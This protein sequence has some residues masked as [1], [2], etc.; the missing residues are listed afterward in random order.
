MVRIRRTFIVLT[1]F[2]ATLILAVSTGA[3][4]YADATEADFELSDF[5][6]VGGEHYCNGTD[7]NEA[8]FRVKINEAA[9]EKIIKVRYDVIKMTSKAD[10]VTVDDEN[11]VTLSPGQVKISENNVIEKSEITK[12]PNTSKYAFTVKTNEN[13]AF[14]FSV[15]YYDSENKENVCYG[16][17]YGED[18]S[19]KNNI[20]YCFKIDNSNPSAYYDDVTFDSGYWVFD[21]FIKGNLNSDAASADSGIKSFAVVKRTA[22]GE[23]IIDRVENIG[24]TQYRYKLKI[25]KEKAAYYLDIVDYA[26]N[27]TTSKIVEFNDVSYDAGFETAVTNKLTKLKSDEKY[28]ATFVEKFQ[29]S[30]DEYYFCIQSVDATEAD[31][32]A[33]MAVCYD[34]MS[35]AADYDKMC[36]NGLS[37][38]TVKNYNTEYF[39]GEIELTDSSSFPVKYGDNAVTTIS[40]AMFDAKTVD[41]TAEKQ[42]LGIKDAKTIY[43]VSI[44][45][46]IDG[47]TVISKCE[48][49]AAIKI[50]TELKKGDAYVVMTVD[51]ETKEYIVCDYLVGNGYTVVYLPYSSGVLNIFT[52]VKSDLLWLWS[53]TA[54]P[55]IAAAVVI[56]IIIKKKK[57][58]TNGKKEK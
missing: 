41:K 34:Y 21:V 10:T 28:S 51:G 25:T 19:K 56:P 5:E 57:D 39:G 1:I 48:T 38:V 30:Y 29:K 37:D 44:N 2:I 17:R 18:G 15:Y 46:E 40:V 16:S 26:G 45:T 14:V 32:K 55:V 42:V 9:Y 24:G 58:K 12:L 7:G 53:L 35:K 47:K 4:A 50:P 13:C 33:K 27:G 49:Y 43:A 54:I 23:S 22:T 3:A 52:G 11:N 6:Q 20:L 8:I 31:I 36:E